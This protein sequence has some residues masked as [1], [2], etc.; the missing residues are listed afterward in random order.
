MT[1]PEI[2]F[3]VIFRT[4]ILIATL[5]VFLAMTPD[6]SMAGIEIV[7]V[8]TLPLTMLPDT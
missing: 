4:G 1:L 5:I 7:A 8:T 3:P 2:M 6:T